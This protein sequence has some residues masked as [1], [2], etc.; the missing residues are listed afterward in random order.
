[1]H[2]APHSPHHRTR[3]DGIFDHRV[4]PVVWL[5]SVSPAACRHAEGPPV[6]LFTSVIPSAWN[7]APYSRKMGMNE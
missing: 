5:L 4:G 6:V 3:S 7:S 2:R 1:M